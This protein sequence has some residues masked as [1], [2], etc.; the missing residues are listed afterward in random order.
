MPY[1]D[2]AKQ[3]E[4]QR[5]NARKYRDRNPN[6]YIKNRHSVY[7]RNINYVRTLKEENPC[8]DCGLHYEYY[9]MQYDHTSDNKDACVAK[10]VAHHHSI[11]RIQAEIDKCELVCAN[12]HAER[13][14]QRRM[15]ERLRI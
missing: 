5:L 11:L 1:K 2:P 8:T 15:A 14:H 10:L 13:T 12:C 6:R 4:F 9:V 7:Q 3:R